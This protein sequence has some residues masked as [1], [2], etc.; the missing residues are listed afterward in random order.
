MTH[1][2]L[3]LLYS[4]QQSTLT[5][6]PGH[7]TPSHYVWKRYSKHTPVWKPC[8]NLV[9][10]GARLWH[11]RWHLVF[12]PQAVTKSK[13]DSGQSVSAMW[14]Q[15]GWRRQPLSIVLS[16]QTSAKT[17]CSATH[18]SSFIFFSLQ[19]RH[20]WD[21]FFVLPIMTD[22]YRMFGKASDVGA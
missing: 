1:D 3:K 22:W 9:H 6:L 10:V 5:V 21:V 14:Y 20:S 4:F 12:H 7:R 18:S 15:H 8:A 11:L 2:T 17:D 16:W 13:T 19:W